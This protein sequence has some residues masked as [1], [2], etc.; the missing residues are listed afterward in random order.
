M[1]DFDGISEARVRLHRWVD[2]ARLRNSV[3]EN[4]KLVCSTS[5][6]S[7][8][9]H[10]RNRNLQTSTAGASTRRSHAD[11]ISYACVGIVGC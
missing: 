2:A 6:I 10:E 1:G 8:Q 9:D 3:T 11:A 5:E 7:G 4:P